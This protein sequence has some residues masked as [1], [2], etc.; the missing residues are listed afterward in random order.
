MVFSCKLGGS[1]M[2][3]V[4]PLDKNVLTLLAT[5]ESAFAID[6]AIQRNKCSKSRKR[7]HFSKLE[8]RFG[9]DYKKIESLENLGLLIDG[10]RKT[11]KNE[12]KKQEG[13][14]LGMLLGTLKASV[15]GNMLTGKGVMRAGKGIIRVGTGP[16]INHMGQNF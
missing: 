4:V 16:N 1:Q 14:F 9:W 11:L 7:N 8:W 13:R 5:M 12:I 3:V 6:S 15:L 2:K 10:V